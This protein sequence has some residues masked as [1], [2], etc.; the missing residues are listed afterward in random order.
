M[1]R[2]GSTEYQIISHELGHAI[3]LALTTNK[4]RPNFAAYFPSITIDGNEDGYVHGMTHSY[5]SEDTL[6]VLLAGLC[7]EA[8]VQGK[9]HVVKHRGTDIDRAKA[10]SSAAEID[11][12][13]HQLMRDLQPYKD[14]VIKF[15]SQITEEF[16]G[17]EIGNTN[18]QIA[19]VFISRFTLQGYHLSI[20]RA[21]ID[22]ALFMK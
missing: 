13:I 16:Y 11:T 17:T 18:T 8:V 2:K 20:N 21:A 19:G 12:T 5:L 14:R 6:S 10:R 22:Q 7:M 15:A 1:I 3:I 9:D 4:C